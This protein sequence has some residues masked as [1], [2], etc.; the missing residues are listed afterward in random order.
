MSNWK[1]KQ[2][3]EFKIVKLVKFCFCTIHSLHFKHLYDCNKNYVFKILSLCGQSQHVY[4]VKLADSHSMNIYN[5]HATHSRVHRSSSSVWTGSVNYSVVNSI[6]GAL[7]SK[8]VSVYAWEKK[9][10][11]KRLVWDFWILYTGKPKQRPH[12]NPHMYLADTI[13]ENNLFT[14]IRLHMTHHTDAWTLSKWILQLNL[15]SWMYYCKR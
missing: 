5:V 2:I 7:S 1:L 13:P 11:D 3:I 8:R 12:R 15:M 4:V 14:S 6:N 9:D 10:L